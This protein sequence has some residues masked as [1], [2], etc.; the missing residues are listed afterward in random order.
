MISIHK[1]VF[2]VSYYILYILYMNNVN[3]MVIWCRERKITVLKLSDI[4][5]V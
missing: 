1:N 5:T 2:S 4:P 3:G